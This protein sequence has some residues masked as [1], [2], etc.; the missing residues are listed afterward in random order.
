MEGKKPKERGTEY[1]WSAAKV[2]SGYLAHINAV[3]R[4]YPKGF[5]KP[6]PDT[7][8]AP[9]QCFDLL[10]EFQSHDECL[11]RKALGD[12]EPLTDE[13]FNQF[14]DFSDEV[15][16]WLREH[17]WEPAQKLE[18]VHPPEFVSVQM[19]E[20]ATGIPERTIRHW[21]AVLGMA[22]IRTKR[23]IYVQTSVV[24]G[25]SKMKTRHRARRRK[26]RNARQFCDET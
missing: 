10:S 26:L 17:P 8:N 24:E 3:H 12:I 21:C 2:L 13:E 4:V 22:H 18:E 20:L 25:W 15:R 19:A 16:E 23:A 14:A 7:A 9:K 11:M 5:S 6:G 1:G